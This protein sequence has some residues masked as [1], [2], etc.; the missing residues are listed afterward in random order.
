[1]ALVDAP[2]IHDDED[3]WRRVLASPPQL[4]YD[5]DEHRWRPSSAAFEDSGPDD[6]MSALL[7]RE[8]TAERALRGPWEGWV[9]AAVGAGMLRADGQGIARA[10]TPEDRSH[11]LVFG[12]KTR[13]M[14][15]RWARLAR[16]VVPP[17]LP[18]PP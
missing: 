2:D 8:D 6:P 7:A 9:L 1:M 5:H 16:W 11:L 10:P 13:A 4:T 12:R 17:E 18:A 15:R 3:V 14:K